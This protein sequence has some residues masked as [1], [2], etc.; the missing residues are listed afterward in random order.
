MATGKTTIG[1]ALARRLGRVFIDS[2]RQIEDQTGSQ[3]SV[4]AAR[5]GVEHL[6]EL[7]WEALEQ[8]LGRSEPA[9]IAAAASV[10]ERPGIDEALDGSTVVWLR[11]DSTTRALRR[12]TSEHRRRMAPDELERV[13]RREPRYRAVADAVIDTTDLA[14]DD[15]VALIGDSLSPGGEHDDE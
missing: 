7:E 14:V 3:G 9:V 15:A 12:A 4:I 5:D 10:I 6:H 8:A 13:A 2:D 1:D 11:A